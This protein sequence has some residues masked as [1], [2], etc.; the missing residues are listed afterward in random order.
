MKYLRLLLFP[1]SFI[2]GL[3]VTIRNWCFDAGIFKSRK[4]Y[5]PVISVGNLDVGGAGKSPMTEYLVRLLKDKYKLATLSRGYG[6]KTKGYFIAAEN[7]PRGLASLIGDEPAQFHQKFPEVTVAVCE[8][9]VV[10]IKTLQVDH[11]L[12]ILDDAYQHRAVHPGLSLLLFD[13]NRVQE[14]HLLL[15]AGNL[16]EP[17]N[18]RKRA[19]AIIITKCPGQLS[20]HEQSVVLAHIKPFTHQQVFF[21]SINYQPLQNLKGGAANIKLTNDTAIF[22]LTGIANA[23][24]LI[25][26]LKNYSQQIIHHKYPDHHRFSLKNI[27]KLADDFAA[28]AQPRKVIITTEKDAQRLTSNELLPLIKDMPVLVM[29]IGIAFLNNEEQKFD[30]F[31][32][33]YVTEYTK[34]HQLY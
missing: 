33:N 6:R 15:P 12:I 10:G 3:V 17:F 8:D 7:A 26:H 32:L 29:P 24:P 25:Q 9:R 34:H 21:T 19:D 30:Q 16:R 14:P 22:L 28:C 23:H 5:I 20:S 1:F 27:S 13:Y 11:N 4:F 18:G 31:V 2:Y